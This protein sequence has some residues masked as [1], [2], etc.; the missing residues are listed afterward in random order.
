MLRLL[1]LKEK[2]TS[3]FARLCVNEGLRDSESRDSET[4]SVFR[5]TVRAA[6]GKDVLLSEVS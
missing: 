4:N 6:G 1:L 2:A 5:E 3:A